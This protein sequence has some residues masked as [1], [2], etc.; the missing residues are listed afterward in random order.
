MNESVFS[1]YVLKCFEQGIVPVFDINYNPNNVSELLDSMSNEDA[2]K[3]K[4]KFRKL[5]RKNGKS[6]TDHR[7]LRGIRVHQRLYRDALS[8]FNSSI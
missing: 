6:K 4:R 1:M 3:M 8:E 7:S 2:R 5:W